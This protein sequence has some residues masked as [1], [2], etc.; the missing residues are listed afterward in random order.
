MLSVVLSLTS[1]LKGNDEEIDISQY[2][3]MAITSF[4][5]A[6]VNK[7][8]TTTSSDGKETVSKTTLNSGL[9]VFSI[10]Q[11]NHQIFNN[12]PL[13]AGCDLK[14]V[15]VTITT[16]RNGQVGIKSLV[17]DSVFTYLYTDS[18]DF[19]QPREFRVYALNGSGYRAYQVTVNKEGSNVSEK[20]W[21]RVAN[22]E[23]IPN[24]LFQ[25]FVLKNNEDNTFQLS[26]DNGNTW[27]N[28][29]LM[30]GE[31]ASLL[32][33]SSI[34]WLSFPYTASPNT[35]YEL[36]IGSCD[37][38][39][40]ACTVWRKIVEKDASQATAQ[41]VNIPL[42]DS[43]EYYLPIMEIISLVWYNSQVYA[44]G[45]NGDIYKTRD[46]GIT[47]KNT[48]DITLPEELGSNHIKA[49][50]DESGQLYLRDLDN[51][52]LWLLTDAPVTQ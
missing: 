12:V 20:Q 35:D 11:Y 51:D 21:V 42:E 39:T 41:W 28:E 17:S 13:A 5:I 36:M 44:F 37:K 4:T 15:L 10:D 22:K 31:D 26:K 23:D 40:D 32:P 18:I 50:T 16:K 14:H 48:S 43:E 2:D 49:A 33:E 9:P 47:W 1:C 34:A 29:V 45:T 6:T 27:T 52:E 38:Q 7:I 3:D 30:D 8:T 24:A 19:S 46:G 25:D